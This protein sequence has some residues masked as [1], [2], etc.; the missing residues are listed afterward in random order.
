DELAARQAEDQASAARTALAM[1]D[2][3]AGST[4][5]PSRLALATAAARDLER[6]AAAL[7]VRAPFD[8]AVYGLPRAAGQVIQPG[9]MVAGVADPAPPRGRAGIDQPALPRI[10]AGQRMIV[11]FSGLP[12][13]SWEGRV[14]AAGGSLRDVG[15]RQVGEATGEIA[16]PARS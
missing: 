11:R 14:T 13:K 2:A 1:I 8:G 4:G 10:A 6:R 15:G 5:S 16:D 9:E 7:S 3:G 12:E